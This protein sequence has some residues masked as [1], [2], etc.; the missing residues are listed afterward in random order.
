M[1]VLLINGQ[2]VCMMSISKLIMVINI[3]KVA[4]LVSSY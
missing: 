1:I 2:L 3:T 4:A